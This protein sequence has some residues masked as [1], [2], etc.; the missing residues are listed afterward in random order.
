MNKGCERLR[1]IVEES[2]MD[3]EFL[4]RRAYQK[5]ERLGLNG[6]ARTHVSSMSNCN[7]F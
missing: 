5:Y 2:K 6:S 1:E 7:L 4:L 3:E